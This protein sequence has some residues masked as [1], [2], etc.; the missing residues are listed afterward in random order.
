[1]NFELPWN[2]VDVQTARVEGALVCTNGTQE[3]LGGCMLSTPS[4]LLPACDYFTV[5]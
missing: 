4:P 1:M 2:S 5:M 3:G